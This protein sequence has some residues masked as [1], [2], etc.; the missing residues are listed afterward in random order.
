[1]REASHADTLAN[2][3]RPIGYGPTARPTLA[4]E[5]IAG[6]YE[7]L[8]LLGVGGMGSVY[9]VR[10]LELGEVVALKFLRADSTQDAQL[11][12]GFRQEVRLARRVTHANVARMFDI[13]EH[14]GQRFLTMECIDGESL[15]NLLAREGKLAE[16]RVVTIGLAL[17]AG[18]AAAHAAGVVHRDLKPDNVLIERSGRVVITDFGIAHAVTSGPQA[19]V[20]VGTAAYMAP[21]QADGVADIDGRADIYALGAVLYELLTGA[22]AW[23]G[24]G[25]AATLM[26]RLLAPPPD[27]RARAP[28]LSPMLSE[29]VLR[30]LARD[31]ERRYAGADAVAE[32]LRAIPWTTATAP[33][34]TAAVAA[35]AMRIAPVAAPGDRS[36]AVLGFRH[37]GPPE[38]AWIADQLVE[39]LIDGLSAVRRLRV[40]PRSA[41]L[42]VQAGHADP[43]AVGRALDVEV[44]VEGSVQRSKDALRVTTRLINVA[45]G[46]QLWARRFDQRAHDLF[47][48]TAATAEAIAAALVLELAAPP[49]RGPTSRGA[50]EAYLLARKELRHAWAGA[51]DLARTVALFEEASAHAPSDPDVLAGYAMARARRLNYNGGRDPGEPT[52]TLALAQRAVDAAPHLGEPWLALATV[53]F[54]TGAWPE[55]VVALRAALDRAPGLVK[56]HEMLA[57]LQLEVGQLD[58]GIYRLETVLSLDPMAIGARGDLAR[59]LA[60]QGRWD[61]ADMLLTLPVERP[62]DRFVRLV[63]RARFDLWRRS[64]VHDLS[65]APVGPFGP[66]LAH[67]IATV[68][69]GVFTDAARGHT[70]QVLAGT[71]PGS[72]VRPLL[73][74]LLAEQY[75]YVGADEQALAAVEAA[76]AGTLHDLSW[77]DRCPT[78][79]RLREHP[80]FV[81]ARERVA[82]RVR[83]VLAALA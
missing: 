55:A 33:A 82:E 10:D 6:R 75:A 71:H 74:Q 11:H 37:V 9:R 52:A 72:R 81:A 57:N 42:A 69:T 36:V 60:L 14:A 8:G 70:E 61:R 34:P 28:G 26:A 41:V 66:L 17:C 2:G 51:G 12:E 4:A 83:P 73:C 35:R 25:F 40:R 5:V 77:L 67:Y 3:V 22:P 44:I 45:D 48:V 20:L 7:V 13:G 65:E 29:I 49:Q 23:S 1:M 18:L 80:R 19:P 50:V 56:A 24:D 38:D 30:C 54:V 58:E 62:E 79:Q 68:R 39:E 16:D 32:A 78:L 31:R 27:P 64:Q 21:E 43:R 47:E 46:F 76:A 59:A 53:R 15:S 63:L